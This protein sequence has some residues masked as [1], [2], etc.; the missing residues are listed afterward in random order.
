MTYFGDVFFLFH[1]TR[2]IRRCTFTLPFCATRVT[3]HGGFLLSQASKQFR[4]ITCVIPGQLDVHKCGSFHDS[5]CTL[6][7][8]PKF[9]FSACLSSSTGQVEKNLFY[10]QSSWVYSPSFLRK[11]KCP[12]L[13]RE[14]EREGKRTQDN[15]KAALR[16]LLEEKMTARQAVKVLHVP[17]RNKTSITLPVTSTNALE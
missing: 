5:L 6:R 15:V 2:E 1:I 7:I 12:K 9:F 8:K 4:C 10:H 14:R 11:E 13:E 3:C 16:A 17:T